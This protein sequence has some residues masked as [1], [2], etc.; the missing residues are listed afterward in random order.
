MGRLNR[1]LSPFST[2]NEFIVGV[3]SSPNCLL[4]FFYQGVAVAENKPKKTVVVQFDFMA[5]S[6]MEMPLEAGDI[7]EVIEKR[8]D[9]WWRGRCDG[10]EGFFPSHFV[11]ELDAN[12]DVNSEASKQNAATGQ[13][14][15][16]GKI[17]GC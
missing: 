17:L 12:E 11:V 9:G 6:P 8:D 4:M 5:T 14:P 16:E 10:K 7:I 1:F 13:S 2:N 3:V 15:P